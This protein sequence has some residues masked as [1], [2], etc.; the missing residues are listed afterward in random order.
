MLANQ[1]VEILKSLSKEELKHLGDFIKSPYFNSS[2]PLEKV[3]EVIQ[4]HY[5][6]FSEKALSYEKVFKKLYPAEEYNEKRMKNLYAEFSSLLKK[7]LGYEKISSDKRDIDIYTIASLTQR[8]LNVISERFIAKSLKDNDDGLLSISDNFNYLFS[9]DVSHS[10]NLSELRKHGSDEYVRTDTVFVE[11]VIIF[12]LVHILQHSFY[13]IMNQ[14]V[15]NLQPN[16]VLKEVLD[17]FNVEKILTYFDK[18]NHE[19]A[20]YLRVH[21]LFYY[22]SFNDISEKEYASFKKEILK[23]IGKVKKTDQNQFLLRIIHMIIAKLVSK[24]QKYYNDVIEFAE[25]FSTLKIYPDENFYVFNIGTFQD[26]FIVAI[27]LRK[28]DWAEKFVNEYINY[29]GKEVHTELENYCRGVL[30]YNRGKYEE[31]LEYLG[32]V[33]LVGITEKINIRFY[34]L[35]NYIELQSYESAYSALLSF[36]QFISSSNEIP[37]MFVDGVNETLKFFAEIIRFKEKGDKPDEYIVK[38]ANGDRTY[39][40][41]GYILNK[42]TS[43]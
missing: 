37:A 30:S 15:F 17:S 11:K 33:K 21:Y 29:I 6:E 18:K 9:L 41:R 42:F 40:Y 12:S 4:K 26:I 13:D 35:M 36:R 22:Y 14:N 8:N 5:P 28:F 1:T 38:E 3:Y 43:A 24:N 32:K 34:Y 23:I 20:S 7:F 27:S 39:F 19:Y 10:M 31:S 16:P 25:M 2:K